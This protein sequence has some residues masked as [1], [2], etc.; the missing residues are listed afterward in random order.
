MGSPIIFF[1]KNHLDFSRTEVVVTASQGNDFIEFIRNRSNETAWMTTGSVD[2]DNTNIEVEFNQEVAIDYIILVKH[3]FKNYTVQYWNGAMYVDFST[4]INVTNNTAETTKHTFTQ[5]LTEKIKLIITGTMIANSD[6]F[7]FQ[8]LAVQLLGQFNGYPNIKSPVNSRNRVISSAL[9]GKKE[10]R[11]NVGFFEC[12]LNLRVYSDTE[13]HDLIQ[14]LFNQHEGFLVW[15][16]GGNEAQFRTLVEGYRLQDLFLVKCANEHKP[17]LYKAG[18]T[19]GIL[20][21]VHLMEVVD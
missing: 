16:S 10:I 3:N 13:D 11:E 18:Y 14:T 2:A 15:L 12:K 20:V 7:L 1:K 5:V 19:N 9:S 6:K 8:F 4:A 21:D 17:E